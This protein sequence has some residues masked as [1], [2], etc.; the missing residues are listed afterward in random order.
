MHHNELIDIATLC[1]SSIFHMLPA[2]LMWSTG[3]TIPHKR[4]IR[5][6][7]KST[8]FKHPVPRFIMESSGAIQVTWN[9]NCVD[10]GSSSNHTPVPALDVSA[11][12]DLFAD[13]S[14]ALSQG[15]VVGVFPEETSYTL[16][17]MVQVPPGAAW[18][19]IEYPRSAR[20]EKLQEMKSEREKL[21]YLNGIGRHGEKTGLEI[22][23][24]GIV[25]EDKRKFM[26]RVSII[27]YVEVVADYPAGLYGRLFRFMLR[28][29][30]WP[31][32]ERSCALTVDGF[33]LYRFG[34]P[35]EIDGYAKELFDEKSEPG[36]AA[37]SVVQKLNTEIERRLVA[38]S[39]NAPDW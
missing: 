39:V 29:L 37:K 18:A 2:E 25:Y 34:E 14:L 1:E 26:S 10:S 30:I 38:L 6:W 15:H 23:P 8:L 22:V 21:I 5:F 7:A 31:Q 33:M 13:T 27:L 3:M 4:P 28:E 19:A 12:I 16:P 9:S 35:I 17:S 20:K 36:Q 32:L 11:P 24:V